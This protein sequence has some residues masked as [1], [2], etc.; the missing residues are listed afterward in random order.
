VV[1]SSAGGGDGCDEGV[2]TWVMKR[3]A[4]VEEENDEEE[5]DEDRGIFVLSQAI[6]LI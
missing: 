5:Y 6:L 4:Y 1:R 3:E 2:G